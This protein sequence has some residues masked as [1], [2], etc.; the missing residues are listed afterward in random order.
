MLC[1]HG[2]SASLRG[3][4]NEQQGRLPHPW[5]QKMNPLW[6]LSRTWSV[7]SVVRRHSLS[8]FSTAVIW[9]HVS[10]GAFIK[11]YATCHRPV[12]GNVRKPC[13]AGST[14]PTTHTQHQL[15]WLYDLLCRSFS[16]HQ[17]HVCAGSSS[18]H[19]L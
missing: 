18:E 11:P 6:H 4:A 8:S 9:K 2:W 17:L 19:T 14:C 10:S 12:E 15:L 5:R 16:I 1:T 7:R 3:G 13:I